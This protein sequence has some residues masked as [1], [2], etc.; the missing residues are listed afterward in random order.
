[1]FDMEVDKVSYPNVE[2]ISENLSITCP[3]SDFG[4]NGIL[5][6]DFQ[7]SNQQKGLV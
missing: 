4:S 7:V 5:S 1:M 6:I 2:S 3:Y